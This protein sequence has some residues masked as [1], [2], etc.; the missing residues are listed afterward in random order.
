MFTERFKSVMG[1]IGYASSITLLVAYFALVGVVFL[2]AARDQMIPTTWW[3][4]SEGGNHG[5]WRYYQP[6]RSLHS[7][8][9]MVLLAAMFAGG[10][11]GGFLGRPKQ[12]GILMLAALVLFVLEFIFL[13]WLVD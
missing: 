12:G 5:P 2:I 1:R 6:V 4:D 13:F 10:I 7:Y 3:D 8:S 11:T 9:L